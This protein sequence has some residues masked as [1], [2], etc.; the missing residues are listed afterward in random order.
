MAPK[1][2]YGD[3]TKIELKKAIPGPGSYRDQTQLDKYGIYH[4]SNYTYFSYEFMNFFLYRNSKATVFNPPSI[5]KNNFKR[6]PGP[7]YYE[8]I[9]IGQIDHI[10][11]SL[12]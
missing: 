10:E 11:Q 4:I 8:T 12:S 5:L 1:L 6:V 2:E 7:G 3:V 9:N